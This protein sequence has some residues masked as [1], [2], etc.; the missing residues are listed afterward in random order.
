MGKVDS[1]KPQIKKEVAEKGI[2]VVFR[3]TARRAFSLLVAL[4]AARLSLQSAVR[5][6]SDWMEESSRRADSEESSSSSDEEGPRRVADMDVD[7]EPAA[8]EETPADSITPDEREVS[9]TKYLWNLEP[10]MDACGTS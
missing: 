10:W 1:R 7:S 6:R 4:Q 3:C 5:C 8:A 9:L 2:I